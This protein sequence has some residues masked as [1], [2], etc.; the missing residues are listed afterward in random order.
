MQN[1]IRLLKVPQA[2]VCMVKIKVGG[3]SGYFVILV[4][5]YGSL[6]IIDSFAAY[7]KRVVI[8]IEGFYAER[9]KT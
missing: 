6:K 2:S 9:E 5:N 3:F 7:N 1:E 8:D 4:M